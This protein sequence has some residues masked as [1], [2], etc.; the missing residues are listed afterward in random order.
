MINLRK[1]FIFLESDEENIKNNKEKSQNATDIGAHEL[2]IENA[3]NPS[4]KYDDSINK[5]FQNLSLLNNLRQKSLHGSVKKT[6]KNRLT[7]N[8]NSSLLETSPLSSTPFTNKIR[9]KSIYKFSPIRMEGLGDSPNYVTVMEEN[10]PNCS[11]KFVP[12]SI[13]NESKLSSNVG[14]PKTNCLHG[15]V[16]EGKRLSNPLF[17]SEDTNSKSTVEKIN[18]DDVLVNKIGND[19]IEISSIQ[20]QTSEIEPFLGYSEN[21]SKPANEIITEE[22]ND[23]LI[24]P[25]VKVSK[26]KQKSKDS[27]NI[28]KSQCSHDSHHIS[29]DEKK[30]SIE[31]SMPIQPFLGFSEVGVDNISSSEALFID[32]QE[33]DQCNGLKD[34][35]N[36]SHIEEHI[37]CTKK[38]FDKDSE[39]DTENED[40]LSVSLSDESSKSSRS[41]ADSHSFERESLYNTC[42]SE[43]S[44]KETIDEV[45]K[46]SVIILE[47]MNTSLFQK[48][49]ARMP[50]HASSLNYQSDNSKSSQDFASF[51]DR[52]DDSSLLHSETNEF[53]QDDDVDIKDLEQPICPLNET[54]LNSDVNETI[55]EEQEDC[56]SFVTTRRRN[57]RTN[58][59]LIFVLNDSSDS[60]SS[61]E[62]D[63]TILSNKIYIENNGTDININNENTECIEV[64]D[65][66]LDNTIIHI[67]NENYKETE[68]NVEARNFVGASGDINGPEY[69]DRFDNNVSEIEP[70]IVLQPGKKWERSLSIYRRITM[71][72]DPVNHSILDEED[73]QYKGRKYR[74]SVIHTMEMQDKGDLFFYSETP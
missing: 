8:L 29:E 45:I 68:T 35:N 25:S 47:R 34:E 51:E 66:K 18:T 7:K 4:P 50:E 12:N 63:K 64:E 20:L 59:S 65:A 48:Y 72:N 37:D 71:M 10:E 30:F 27:S 70:N 67:D 2:I 26:G 16:S 19:K 42:S 54:T 49:Y 17:S 56:R 61:V 55:Q 74:Q 58:N 53:G 3:A 41:T 43:Q 1:C 11:I 46:D 9:S 28:G 14:S 21:T 40:S 13:G 69:I 38:E 6:Y 57:E 39:Q 73:L 33:K 31:Y 23:S 36:A 5:I 44:F 15:N 60:N 32:Q 24:L 62:F 22:K 52:D